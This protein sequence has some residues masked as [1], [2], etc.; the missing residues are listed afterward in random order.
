MLHPLRLCSAFVGLTVATSVVWSYG[1]GAWPG[2]VGTGGMVPL[3]VARKAPSCGDIGCHRPFPGGL[4]LAVALA[5]T[6]RSLVQNQTI[7]ITTSAT[8]GQTASTW[9][10][11]VT[12]ATAGVF[13]PGANSQI[14]SVAGDVVTHFN[15][16][17]SNGR[18]W[19]YG[20]TAPATPG[21]VEVYTVVNTVNGDGISNAL[22]FWGFHGFSSAATIATPVRLYVNATR[23]TPR[24]SSC[25]GS[26][27]QYPVLGSK[28]VPNVGN[29]AFALELHGASPS[30]PF[31]L[32]LGANPAWQPLDL[33]PFGIAGCTL[34]VD[35]LL[36]SA[37][38][39]TAGDI[40]RAEGT[41]TIPLPIPNDPAL[42]GGNVQAQ[43]VIVDANAPRPLKVTLTNG[44][45]LA[46]L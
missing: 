39:T 41:A 40:L 46:I 17:N 14:G 8:G 45:G 3:D 42:S 9:G 25:V 21:L 44:L 5:P 2:K 4:S 20:Y 32:V 24:G 26:W 16:T 29:A 34:E 30:A 27:G 10:G 28:T 38:T 19:T 1:S 18:V 11:F 43:A 13:T 23:V 7:S 12:Q 36:N 6:A 37:G 31:A 33:T 35:V 22:D 15:A